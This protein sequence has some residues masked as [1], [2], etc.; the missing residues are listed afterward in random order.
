MVLT[1]EFIYFIVVTGESCKISRR[2][3]SLMW[4]VKYG[5]EGGTSIALSKDHSYLLTTSKFGSKTNLGKLMEL[6]G[7][8]ISSLET[9]IN[10]SY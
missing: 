8:F 4:C 7:S 6:N 3:S 9:D 5:D 1:E 10:G 2:N